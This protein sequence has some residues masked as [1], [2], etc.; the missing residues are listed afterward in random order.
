MDGY[1]VVFEHEVLFRDLDAMRHV[2]N[3]AYLAFMEDARVQYWNALRKDRD[4]KGINFILA[5]IT[6][7][8]LSPAH[9]GET[10]LI[11]IRARK[12]GNKSFQF[13]YRME[14]KESGRLIT[15]GKSVQVMYDYKQKQTMPLDERLRDAAAVLEQLT[16][17]ELSNSQ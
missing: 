6:C 13:E 14:E 9:F 12:L 11:G 17:E 16:V 1:Q 8:Y 7:R 2:N 5:E 4:L 3:V 15:E 10:L